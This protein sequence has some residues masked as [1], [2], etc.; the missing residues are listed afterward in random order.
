M[1]SWGRQACYPQR[2]FYPMSDGHSTLKNRRIT[3]ACFRICLTC[4]SHS[5]APLCHYTRRTIAD[6]AEGTFASLRYTLGGDRPSQTT[7]LPL[8]RRWI[9]TVRLDAK[10]KKGS[11]PR[12]APRELAL[13]LQSLLP[14][15]YILYL[16]P[17]TSCSKGAQGLSVLLRV[18]SVFTRS[19]TS[20]D[21]PKRQCSTRYAIRAGRNLPDKEFRYLRT[22]IVTAAV[23]RGFNSNLS[24]LLLTFRHWAGVSPYTSPFS[25]AQTCVFAKQSFEPLHCG[26]QKLRTQIPSPSK[27]PLLPKLRGHFAE[28]LSESQ[29]VRLRFLILPTCVGLRYGHLY[30]NVRSFSW[31]CRINTFRSEELHITPQIQLN[32]FSYQAILHACTRTTVA[33]R[34]YLT[35]SLHHKIQVVQEYQPTFHS[36]TLLSLGLGPGFPRED[37]LYPGNLGLPAK[38]ILTLF[39]ATHSCI[40]TSDTSSTP[41]S[42][43]STAYR[44]LSYQCTKYTP[45]LR[46][47]SQ[48]RYIVGAGTL[49]Q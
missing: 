41:Y 12:M 43:P 26:L 9:H 1:N 2:T 15:L 33:E 11:I 38:G 18:P 47:I 16:A 46:F 30:F 48:P 25:L 14:I 40:L 13:P 7:R 6:R 24:I 22:V 5:Q 23:H 19:S 37:K 35:A 17:M 20:P 39:L 21:P 10:Y 29:P 36:P 44:T 28:F 49:D 34:V 32:G 27:A 8:F 31:Q 42:I 3:M 45:Q 4:Q